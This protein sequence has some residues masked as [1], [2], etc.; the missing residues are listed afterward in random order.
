MATSGTML[1]IRVKSK[2]IG[3]LIKATGN[4]IHMND[5]SA[6]AIIAEDLLE[7]AAAYA[8]YGEEAEKELEKRRIR[9]ALL[10]GTLSAEEITKH[11]PKRGRPRKETEDAETGV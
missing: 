2:T 9:E 3:D 4:K 10:A 8:A 7:W 11:L 1:Y 5:K 6:L